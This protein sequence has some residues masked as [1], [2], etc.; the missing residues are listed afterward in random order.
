MFL[1]E[2]LE[3]VREQRKQKLPVTFLYKVWQGQNFDIYF[4]TLYYV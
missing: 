4:W 3:L 2:K 1:I